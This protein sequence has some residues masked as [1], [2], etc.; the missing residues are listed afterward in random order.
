MTKEE[1]KENTWYL[2]NSGDYIKGILDE[3][4]DIEVNQYIQNNIWYDEL[5][6]YCLDDIDKEIDSYDITDLLPEDHED[7]V[8]ITKEYL[9]SE[10]ERIKNL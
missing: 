7:K 10:L 2:M 3:D 9:V 5:G 6:Y 8:L 4:D 1:F